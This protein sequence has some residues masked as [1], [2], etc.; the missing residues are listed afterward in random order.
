MTRI[1]EA[2]RL[3]RFTADEF[4]KVIRNAP[5]AD[6]EV[7]KAAGLLFKPSLWS[8][9]RDKFR[10]LLADCSAGFINRDGTEAQDPRVKDNDREVVGHDFSF[11]VS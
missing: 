11:Q 4:D 5:D 7:K 6:Q 8:F 3:S 1:D 10:N 9:A 2:I